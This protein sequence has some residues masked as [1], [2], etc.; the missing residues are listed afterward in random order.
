ML[1]P[2]RSCHHA[3]LHG[4]R[5]GARER[6]LNGLWRD[7]AQKYSVEWLI[8][9][10]TPL[11]PL[12]PAPLPENETSFLV[13]ENSPGENVL[14]FPKPSPFCPWANNNQ[15]AS[16]PFCPF[17]ST[18]FPLFDPAIKRPNGLG[19]SFWRGGGF[20]ERKEK[21]ATF[22]KLSF[23]VTW[24]PT[25]RFF[26]SPRENW[27]IPPP[28]S[29]IVHS[30]FSYH[31]QPA[32]LL[33]PPPPLFPPIHFPKWSFPLLPPPPEEKGVRDKSLA[34]SPPRPYAQME[35][36]RRKKGESQPSL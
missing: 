28:W 9:K 34:A 31:R 23:V 2:L 30:S 35:R 36:G 10:G 25:W 14:F 17:S 1:L 29:I 26:Y 15:L 33:P 3:L 13:N 7:H 5:G 4:K 6:L 27:R 24:V 19:S 11:P 32:N 22:K 20:S 8:S 12:P 18:S 21:E 16:W